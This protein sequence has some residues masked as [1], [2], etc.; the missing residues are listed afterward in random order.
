MLRAVRTGSAVRGGSLVKEYDELVATWQLTPRLA[1][2]L[3]G[4]GQG[5]EPGA[6][7]PSCAGCS[8][9]WS[10]CRSWPGA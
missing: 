7:D 8:P 2:L 5:A 4:A 1:Q 10:P 6:P 9:R 3:A